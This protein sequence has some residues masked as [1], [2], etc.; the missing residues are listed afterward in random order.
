MLK[1][2]V[3]VLAKLYPYIFFTLQLDSASLRVES[4]PIHA[5]INAVHKYLSFTN[6]LLWPVC[7]S[8]KIG[9]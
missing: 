7:S 8:L 6:W 5:V 2:K 3:N 1:A 9:V 4:A